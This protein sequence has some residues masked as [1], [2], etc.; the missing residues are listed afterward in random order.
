MLATDGIW[1][2]IPNDEVENIIQILLKIG[3]DFN[4]IARRLVEIAHEKWL[5]NCENADDTTVIILLLNH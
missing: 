4:T 3:K 5:E 1:D 2:V